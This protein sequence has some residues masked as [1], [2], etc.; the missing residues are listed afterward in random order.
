[1][2]A[3]DAC[4]DDRR[5]AR[6][7]RH[8]LRDRARD[9]R[10]PERPA[11]IGADHAAAG[12]DDGAG[13]RRDGAS[14]PHLARD[15]RGSTPGAATRASAALELLR[16]LVEAE[17]AGSRA[18]T[19]AAV[20]EVGRL[21][22]EVGRYEAAVH[23]LERAAA[24]APGV[25]P[26]REPARIAVNRCEALLALGRRDECLAL[27]EQSMPLIPDAFPR[28]QF[29]IRVLQGALPA[30]DGPGR[31]SGGGGRGA[32]REISA[33]RAILPPRRVAA[34]RRA[35]QAAERPRRRGR[36]AATKALGRFADDDLPR[37]EVEARIHLAELLAEPR[38]PRRG[39][40]L[41]RRGAQALRGA[42]TAGDGRPGAGGGDPVLAARQDRR[43]VGRRRDRAARGRAR[44]PLPRHGDARQRRLRLGA[45]GDRPQHRRRSRDQADARR[46]HRRRRG[47]RDDHRNRA[48]R[49]AGRGADL[50]PPLGGADALPARR[51]DGRD[52]AGP[53]FRARADAAARARRR[54]GRPGRGD[55]RSRRS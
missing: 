52:R 27:A 23:M 9:R 49:G 35:D 29:T 43:P 31:G 14:C 16:S 45:A 26:A 53:G 28:E 13:S 30:G 10:E 24:L 25:L 38:P 48:E 17:A 1:M 7:A 8:P 6:R 44:R 11:P 12:A 19:T 47:R 36:I 55:W 50:R 32:R 18:D 3:L 51:A 20:A 54:L 41:H 34:S 40:E 15:R 5:R 4:A 42:R 39:G 46:R 21:N 22:L 37:H 33:G 2:R